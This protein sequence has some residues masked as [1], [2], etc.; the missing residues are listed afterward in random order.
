MA[1]GSPQFIQAV[2]ILSACC[3]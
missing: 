3:W 2:F 1:G